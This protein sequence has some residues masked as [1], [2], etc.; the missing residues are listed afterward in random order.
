MC[1]FAGLRPADDGGHSGRHADVE[2]SWVCGRLGREDTGPDFL[3]DVGV[4]A[5]VHGEHIGAADDPGQ[6]PVRVDHRQALNVAQV[7]EPGGLLDGVLGPHGVRGGRHQLRRRDGVRLLLLLPAQ[8]AGDHAR[9]PVVSEA[10]GQLRQQ[11]RLGDDAD[12]LGCL[13]KHGERADPVLA[14]GGGYN[15]ERRAF[16]D[17]DHVGRHDVPD[18]GVHQ[19]SSASLGV[20]TTLSAALASGSPKTS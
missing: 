12:H 2:G 17:G 9:H 16:A 8:D 5:A 3:R 20:S 14:Q 7:H 1:L 19:P 6:A 10:K 13:V 11:V 18:D 4:G 15:L